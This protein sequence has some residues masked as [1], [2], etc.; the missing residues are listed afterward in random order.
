MDMYL[1]AA[2]PGRIFHEFVKPKSP[3]T[4]SAIHLG[5][6]ARHA[7]QTMDALCAGTDTCTGI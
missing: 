3:A 7:T 1:E 2:K 6:V 5:H 4:N